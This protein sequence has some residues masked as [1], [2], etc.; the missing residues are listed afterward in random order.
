MS[1]QNSVLKTLSHGRQFTAGQMADL[2]ST[3]EPSVVARISELRAR[4]Y[5]IYSNTAKNGKTAYRL[6][7][8]SRRMI[9][10]AYAAAGSSVFN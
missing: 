8:P 3:S 1:L 9:A 4:G 5:S 2:F 7:T 10:A 6:G